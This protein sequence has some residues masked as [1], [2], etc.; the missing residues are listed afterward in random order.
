MQLTAEAFGR[1]FLE[2]RSSFENIAFSY[3]NDSDAAKDIVTD[4]FMYLWE[5][6]ETLEGGG[7][8]YQGLPVHVCPCPMHIPSAQA[9]DSP[10]GQER[11]VGRS[12]MENRDKSGRIVG[13]RAFRP[14]LP[15]GNPANIQ[16]RAGQD[17]ETDQGHFPGKPRGRHDIYADCGKIQ[18]I[19]PQSHLGNPACPQ[20][21]PPLPQRLSLQIRLRIIFLSAVFCFCL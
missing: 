2:C 8:Q 1:L 11:I 15:R 4:S 12:Q 13:Q 17:A 19:P 18:C 14:S 20:T 6:R 9:A 16:Q 21:P 7:R 10:Q 5:H 3:I